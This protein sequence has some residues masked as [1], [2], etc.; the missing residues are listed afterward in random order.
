MGLDHARVHS[1]LHES[2]PLEAPALAPRIAHHP[3]RAVV[4][5]G[6]VADDHH[7]VV[8]RRVPDARL[9]RVDPRAVQ[10]SRRG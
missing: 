5:I 8:H 4:G 6:A 7:A 2:V 1:P 10:F 3:V 9:A